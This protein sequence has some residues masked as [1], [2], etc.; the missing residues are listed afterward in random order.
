MAARLRH[1]HAWINILFRV[2]FFEFVIVTYLAG[3]ITLIF[4]TLLAAMCLTYRW[5]RDGVWYAYSLADLLAD[6]SEPDRSMQSEG[7]LFEAPLLTTLPTVGGT[8]TVAS[9]ALFFGVGLFLSALVASRH[10]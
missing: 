1:D 7:W 2:V 9:L 8:L 5:L 3:T 4:G 6:G 10:H